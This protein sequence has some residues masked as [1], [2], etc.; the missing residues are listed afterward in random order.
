MASVNKVILIG[1]CGRDPE[2]RYTAGGMAMCNIS[3]ATSSKR[4]DK[5]SGETIEETQWHR[6][7]FFDKLAE[8]AGEYLRKGKPVYVE[9]RLKYGKYT[10]KDG[11]ERNTTDIVAEVM[12]ML[13][14]RDGGGGMGS[15]DEGG[16]GAPAPR[17]MPAR[18]GPSTGGAPARQAPAA[19][20][21][22]GGGQRGGSATGFDDMDDDIPF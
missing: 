8:I 22:G 13:G 17:A 16:G 6:V 5:A 20:G 3:V 1:N 21:G 9:G 7:Q 18:Q 4:K 10:D 2:V 19:S 14:G 15:M 11:I 12:Q